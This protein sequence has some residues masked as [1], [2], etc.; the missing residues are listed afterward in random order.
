MRQAVQNARPG[1]ISLGHP[2]VPR[3]PPR[4]CPSRPAKRREDPQVLDPAQKVAESVAG[5]LHQVFD[6]NLV[7]V[8]GHGSSVKG[9]WIH[10]FSDFDFVIFLESSPTPEHYLD[11]HDALTGIDPGPFA[12]LQASAFVDVNVRP[13]PLLVPGALR[14]WAGRL[15]D[16]YLHTN[17]SLRAEGHAWL[18]R[19]PDLI[20]GDLASWSVA[21]GYARTRVLRL[22][23]TRLLPALR[24]LL[25]EAGQEPLD[26][27][28]QPI[29]ELTARWNQYNPTIGRLLATLAAGLPGTPST[30]S[31]LGRDA[32]TLA[33][34]I[35]DYHR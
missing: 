23:M 29:T 5:A 1:A 30:E 26:V 19:L 3:C 25:V 9:G 31:V 21:V 13:H 20:E 35:R 28:V 10:H 4:L 7:G 17:D 6:G 2:S 33:S 27:W 24:A 11:L 34:A 18:K 15:P 32:F 16:G 12:Y 14:V 8:V 22:V